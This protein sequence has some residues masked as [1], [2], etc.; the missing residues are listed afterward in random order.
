MGFLND[1]QQKII[2]DFI[3]FVVEELGIENKP[4]VCVQNN[5]DGIKTTA[6]YDYSKEKKVVKVCMKNR[7]LV[8]GLRSIAHE[9]VHHKQWEEGRLET[10]PEDIGGDIEDEANAKAG[11]FIKMFSKINPK[12]YDL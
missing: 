1:E 3:D 6:L 11:Q 7:A 5:R 8:D 12:I 4:S 2:S 9:I 10:K